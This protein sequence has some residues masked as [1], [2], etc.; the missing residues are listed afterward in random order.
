MPLP[1]R[2]R[3]ENV[4]KRVSRHFKPPYKNKLEKHNSLPSIAEDK[5]TKRPLEYYISQENLCH[6]APGCIVWLPA[7]EDILPG[8][9]I[10]GRLNAKAFNHPAIIISVPSP[11]THNSMVELA[12]VSPSM[13]PLPSHMPL[14]LYSASI[15][16]C[17]DDF[18]RWAYSA[19]SI[20]TASQVS[21]TPRKDSRTSVC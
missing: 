14:S 8:A 9:M 10:D 3:R 21:I 4:K 20:Q 15:N 5:L 13:L 18:L 1:R 6:V 12:I 17:K 11:L 16:A 2:V 19:P 7:K